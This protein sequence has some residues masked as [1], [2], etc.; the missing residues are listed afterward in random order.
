MTSNYQNMAN[1]IRFLSADAVQKA[2]SGH[3]GMP[4]GMADVATV[5]FSDFLKF[6]PKDPKWAD[7]DRFILSAGHGSMLLYSLFYLTGYEDATIDQI[8][9]FR[10]LHSLAAGHPEYGEFKGTEMTTGPLGQGIATSVGFALAER[11]LNAHFSD[12]LVDHY[13]W[14]IAGDGCLMEGISQEAITLAGHLGLSKLIVLWDNNDITIDG[15]VSVAS[16]ESQA[17]RFEAAGW[18][19]L[20]CDGHNYDD[21]HQ[22]LTQAKAFNNGKPTMVA[23]KTIIGKGAPTKSDSHDVHGAPLGDEE[24]AKMREAFGWD[25]A[26]F[27]VPADILSAWREVAHRNKGEYDA[28]QQ[29]LNSSEYKKEFSRI[30][31]KGDLPTD[32]HSVVDDFKKKMTEEA[33]SLAT[34]AASGKVLEVLTAHIPELVGGSADLTGSVNTK[35]SST[36]SLDKNHYENRYIHWGVREHGMAAGMNGLALHGGILPY[37][38]TFAVFADYMRG[39]IRLSA[40]MGTNVA[41]VLT[42]DSIGLGEDG[43]THQPVET[44]ASLRAMPNFDTMRPCDVIE[45]LECWML[46]LESKT[47]PAGIV[48][49]RQAVPMLRDTY[50]SE[51]LSAKGAYILREAKGDAVV[52]IMATGTEVSVAVKAAE[53]L[54]AK[55]IGAR[56]VSVPCMD[57]FEEQSAEYKSAVL[58]HGLRVA[59]E[60]AIRQPW[61]RYLRED[62]IFVGMEGFGLS[63]PAELL[64]KHFGITAENI[65]HKVEKALA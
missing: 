64:Y 16:S 59:V 4:M 38:G 46:S 1:A 41:Y 24:I 47:R 10:Q 32:I 42:H 19:V 2:K 17:K 52:T 39:S 56:V 14:V 53:N 12:N 6:N 11:M 62:D 33:P 31:I 8:K 28:W 23:C 7:R 61:D 60:A 35:T 30:V 3:P 57:R 5:L 29:R 21:I 58:G 27:E 48:L 36:L 49:S 26:P 63:A 43:P 44:L 22:A 65:V 15:H 18:N 51:N 54:N 40:L 45:T 55:G 25:Y 37:S 50:V 20:S 34:R 9:N 13:T